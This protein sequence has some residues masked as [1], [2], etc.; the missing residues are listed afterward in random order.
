MRYNVG[1]LRVRSEKM[2]LDIYGKKTGGH[3]GAGYSRLHFTARHLALIYCAMPE[4]IDDQDKHQSILFYMNP[5]LNIGESFSTQH[6]KDFIY[7]M[8]LSGVEFPNLMLHSD[9]EGNYT[10]NGK[11]DI[12]GSLMT[13]N[14]IALLRE[15]EK[16]V[17]EE[18]FLAEKYSKEMEYTKAFY[19]LVKDEIENGVGTILF[20]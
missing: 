16:L 6:M 4:F 11:L 12:D 13:G 17:N 8:Q 20:R 7:A 3:L 9:C 5:W 1:R 15:L 19:N 2:G 14:S 18:A 10:K